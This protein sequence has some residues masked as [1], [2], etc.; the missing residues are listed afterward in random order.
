MKPRHADQLWTPKVAAVLAR[1]SIA[2]LAVQLSS[3]PHVTPLLFAATPDRLWFGIA[4]GTLKARVVAKRPAVG[5]VV[6]GA[7]ASVAIRGEA[8]LLDRLT[9][10]PAELARTPLALPAFASQNALEIAAFARDLARRDAAAQPLALVSVRV[11][12]VDLLDG[13]PAAA[14]LGWTAPG[15]LLA[16]PATWDARSG[17]ARVPAVALKRAGGPRVAHACICVD[18]SEGRGPLAKRGTLLRGQGRARLRGDVASI[19]LEPERVTRWRGF[20]TT[21]ADVSVRPRRI[22]DARAS[23]A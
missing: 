19:A 22:I 21:T 4:R 12:A 2:Y 5:V 16:L 7:I 8:T 13:W 1:A 10:A 18:Q 20:E 11:E 6:P 23:T 17:R 3:G 15:G 9:A 14:V